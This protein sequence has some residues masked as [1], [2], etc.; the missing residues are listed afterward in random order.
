MQRDLRAVDA[1]AGDDRRGRRRTAPTARAIRAARPAIDRD[2]RP[3][4]RMPE[5][6]QV[7]QPLRAARSGP[8]TPPASASS[9]QVQLAQPV[10]RLRMARRSGAS[11]RTS[12]T[13]RPPAM[14]E[15]APQLVAQPAIGFLA[16]EVPRA[17]PGRGSM[18][19]T[20]SS[21][22]AAR[23]AHHRAPLPLRRGERPLRL[24]QPRRIA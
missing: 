21:M 22:S 5:Q 18:R 6:A 4:G 10:A 9:A 12:S 24:D 1:L 17:I 19:G 20:A 13:R 16:V 2:A 14:V 11:S 3:R 15:Q 7:A 8:G 23:A